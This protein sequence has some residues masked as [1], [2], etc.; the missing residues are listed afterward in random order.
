MALTRHLA[1]RSIQE[2]IVAIATAPRQREEL[3]RLVQ[4]RWDTISIGIDGY[5]GSDTNSDLI[6]AWMTR[7]RTI[8]GRM[9]HGVQG[10]ATGD[11]YSLLSTVE[12]RL[13]GELK[14]AA[15]DLAITVETRR[16]AA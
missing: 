1:G 10:G 7:T 6:A 15:T 5:D 16:D 9:I 11:E 14:A 4:D 13:I 2:A 3:E 8:L 12:D